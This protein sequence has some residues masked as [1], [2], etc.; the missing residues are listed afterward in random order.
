MAEC[1]W[2]TVTNRVAVQRAYGLGGTRGAS[3]EEK[4]SEEKV[5]ARFG[6]V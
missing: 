2:L 3:G 1:G 5:S 4:A 6:E